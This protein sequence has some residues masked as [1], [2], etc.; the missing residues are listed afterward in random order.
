M[1]N[2]RACCVLYVCVWG[3]MGRLLRCI[4]ISR[5]AMR[6]NVTEGDGKGK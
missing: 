3:V 1:I 5:R 4:N 6:P 2:D